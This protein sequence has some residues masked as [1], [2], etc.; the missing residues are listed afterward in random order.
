[1]RSTSQQSDQLESMRRLRAVTRRIEAFFGAQVQK[2]TDAMRQL[3][4]MQAEYEA[5]K[6]LSVDLDQQRSAWREER[7]FEVRRL[8]AANEA[9]AK[10][11]TE[12]EQQRREFEIS[13]LQA[14]ATKTVP[15]KSAGGATASA[16]APKSPVATE[17]PST[18]TINAEPAKSAA[19]NSVMERFVMQQL[20]NQVREH[21]RRKR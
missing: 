4:N 12:L 6:R 2:L 9:L 7:D 10:S 8:E 14:E 1:M 19:D 17:K 5:A 11:W 21:Q 18:T 20:Q 3:E 15:A 16:P 13:R